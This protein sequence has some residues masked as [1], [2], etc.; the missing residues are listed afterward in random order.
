MVCAEQVFNESG[1]ALLVQQ[2][3]V[4]AE[5]VFN[6]SGSALLVQQGMVCAEQVFNKSGSSLLVACHNVEKQNSKQTYF[7]WLVN[8]QC[9]PQPVKIMLLKSVQ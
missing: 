5:Q 4:Y 6:E 2:G 8:E 1:S 9:R 7:D 3:M